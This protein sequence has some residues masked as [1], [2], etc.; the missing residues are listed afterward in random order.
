MHISS[1]SENNHENLNFNILWKMWPFVS[2]KWREICL[3]YSLYFVYLTPCRS[4]SLIVAISIFYPLPFYFHIFSLSL[5]SNPHFTSHLF[6]FTLFHIIPA[7]LHHFPRQTKVLSNAS[8]LSHLY[9]LSNE[10]RQKKNR[11]GFV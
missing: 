8:L 1:W 6:H 7:H 11:S 5:S 3:P 4:R 10:M 9:K 2:S